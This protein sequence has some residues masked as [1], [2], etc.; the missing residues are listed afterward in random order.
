M[1]GACGR[2]VVTDPV[3]GPNRTMRQHL[4]V[5]QT[6]NSVC[7]TWPGAPKVVATAGGWLVSGPTGATVAIAT[8]EGLWAAVHLSTPGMRSSDLKNYAPEPGAD[9]DLSLR[10]LSL[11]CQMART[12]DKLRDS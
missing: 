8:V 2:S 10:V 11:G 9:E 6:I 12:A 1:C 3:L 7:H 5:A 4:I